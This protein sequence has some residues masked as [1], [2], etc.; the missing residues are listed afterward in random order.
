[1]LTSLLGK[2]AN[3][4][5]TAKAPPSAPA[6]ARAVALPPAAKPAIS[7]KIQAPP[8]VRKTAIAL[9]ALTVPAP[10]ANTT[11]PVA[12][13][14]TPLTEIAPRQAGKFK[15]GEAAQAAA[16]PL[17][18]NISAAAPSHVAAVPQAH[19]ST[20]TTPQ[21]PSLPKD[22]A[23]TNNAPSQTS[24]ALSRAVSPT[25]RNATTFR[26]GDALSATP[27]PASGTAS[28]GI[29]QPAAA[30]DTVGGPIA[31]ARATPPHN[32]QLQPAA[33]AAPAGA[34]SLSPAA[35]GTASSAIV[36]VKQMQPPPAIEA[37]SRAHTAQTQAPDAAPATAPATTAAPAAAPPAP[38][39]THTVAAIAAPAA[40]IAHAV[41]VHIAAGA[42]GNVTIHLQPAELGA[43]QVRIERAHDGSATVTVQVEKSETL[44]ALQ[45]DM[46]RLH[47]AL[48]RAGLP[49]E[50]RQVTLHLAAATGSD[51][52]T[53][54]GNSQDG[55]R[56]NANTRQ[57][58]RP[59]AALPP[60]L[61][62]D[63]TAPAWRAAGINITA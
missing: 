51:T 25:H 62:D 36:P 24:A 22:A 19:K 59:A 20:D 9:A 26:P 32:P 58:P 34:A 11:P 41:A 57:P 31:G 10:A 48:D 50:A 63:E 55:Q 29:A 42:T 40:Q 4:P 46:P 8:A 60:D 37:L 33:P 39:A 28:S 44:H 14:A 6:E 52:Q 2:M 7:A 43:V 17:L 54:L 56:Q 38:T 12:A 5:D 16:A 49:T 47:Q 13:A 3:P 45:Q 35:T 18:A 1:M 61:P 53:S 23:C 21:L 15:L 30:L 27:E